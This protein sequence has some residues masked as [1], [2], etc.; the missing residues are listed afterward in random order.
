M[1]DCSWS[2]SVFRLYQTKMNF[3]IF[4]R[5]R[6]FVATKVC[7]NFLFESNF[8]FFFQFH[9]LDPKCY[10]VILFLTFLPH[11]CPKIWKKFATAYPVLFDEISV[12]FI[13][14][15][16]KSFKIIILRVEYSC[17]KPVLWNWNSNLFIS[18][19]LCQRVFFFMNS[20]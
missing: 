5:T 2:I 13:S 18:R 3:S 9:L 12:C 1:D 15:I 4:Y 19:N 10:A 16:K 11:L 17:G 14:A 6:L 7:D 8:F 20:W